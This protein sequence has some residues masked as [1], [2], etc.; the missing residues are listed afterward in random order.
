MAIDAHKWFATTM[1]AGMFL[2][3]RPAI[4]RTIFDV[5]SGYMPESC[6]GPD[7]YRESILWS[8]RF[9]GLRLFM[10]LATAGW[11]GISIHVER[12]RKLAGQLAER[13]ASSGWRHVNASPA[14]VACFLP[15]EGA[16]QPDDIARSLQTSGQA[17]V[18]AV[19]FE[20][21]RVVRACITN[22]RT[23]PE[24]IDA[25]ADAMDRA[26]WSGSSVSGS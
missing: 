15:P 1:G 8:R 11:D 24:D 4:L 3:P 16:R 21:R 10:A 5:A 19:D 22:A 17:W 23:T 18:G 14:A 12:A 20:G 9:V 25:I 2:T 7:Y 26:A 6:G 13:M